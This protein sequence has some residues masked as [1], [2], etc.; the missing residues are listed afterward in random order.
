MKPIISEEGNGQG[1]DEW[2]SDPCTTT[3]VSSSTS[4]TTTSLAEYPTS[5]QPVGYSHTP[6]SLRCTSSTSP[7]SLPT[8]APTA[9]FGV[10]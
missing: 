1:C 7:A 8:T 5:A 9:T 4:F 2:Y 10:T 3:P 6:L